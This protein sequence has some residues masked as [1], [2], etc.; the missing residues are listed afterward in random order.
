MIDINSFKNLRL[1]GGFVI[2]EMEFTPEP[3][4]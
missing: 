3:F 1:L 2:V 4:W